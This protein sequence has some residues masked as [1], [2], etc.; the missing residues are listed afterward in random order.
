MRRGGLRAPPCSAWPV[1]PVITA[2]LHCGRNDMEKTDAA[3][4]GR[5]RHHGG[6]SLRQRRRRRDRRDRLGRPRHH[7][8][9]SLRRRQ[10]PEH[11]PPGVQVV[12]VITA[13]LHCG[14]PICRANSVTVHRR[15]R[16]HGGAS[17]RLL[18]LE[19]RAPLVISRPRHHGGA[20]LRRRTSEGRPDRSDL[21][22][23]S[24]RRGFIA[25]CIAAWFLPKMTV[26]VPVITAGL[27]CGS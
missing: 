23:P 14:S 6:A 2:G 13:G 8:G 15:P 25:A 27:H 3:L 17:L 11:T 9:A 19:L 12:P 5:P 1:V 20:S 22:S 7:G 21:S 24:S 18:T 4:Y 26:V 16:H 10:P